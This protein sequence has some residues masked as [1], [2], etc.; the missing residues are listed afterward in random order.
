[1][2]MRIHGWMVEWIE[3]EKKRTF[4]NQ[5]ATHLSISPTLRKYHTKP[6]TF[7]FVVDACPE[8][9]RTRTCDGPAGKIK[10]TRTM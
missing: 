10:N 3:T 1:M 7:S 2:T 5:Y 6:S 9:P 8:S 4:D